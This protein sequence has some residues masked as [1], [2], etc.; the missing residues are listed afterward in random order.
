MIAMNTSFVDNTKPQK[1]VQSWLQK[2]MSKIHDLLHCK[3]KI[4]EFEEPE[5]EPMALSQVDLDA[6]ERLE[7]KRRPKLEGLPY[8][9]LKRMDYISYP[10]WETCFDIERRIIVRELALLGYVYLGEEKVADKWMTFYTGA[11][12]VRRIT[13]PTRNWK[14]RVWFG[15]PTSKNGKRL[16]RRNA[17]EMI[18]RKVPS[19]RL[20][21]ELRERHIMEEV[22]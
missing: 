15:I 21:R 3:E 4:L 1:S 5:E 13:I 7:R 10:Y 11:E 6:I 9:L 12:D 18:D 16:V 2:A 8:E 22:K 19:G 17:R 20:C 14:V